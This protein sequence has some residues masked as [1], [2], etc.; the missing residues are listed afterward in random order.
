[1]PSILLDAASQLWYA[2]CVVMQ[3]S[4]WFELY[5]S[6]VDEAPFF[7]SRTRN[8][9]HKVNSNSTIDL[10]TVWSVDRKRRLVNVGWLSANRVIVREC[11]NSCYL[12]KIL[13]TLV[14]V[15]EL[16]LNAGGTHAAVAYVVY[17]ETL[18]PSRVAQLLISTNVQ[19]QLLNTACAIV[20]AVRA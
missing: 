3:R 19:S 13:R 6:T 20:A 7:H 12:S 11:Q 17:G 2:A 14:P 10:D 18:L 8:V 4:R 5:K 16:W 15:Y 9:I 1:M